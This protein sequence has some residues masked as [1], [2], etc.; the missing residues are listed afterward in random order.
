MFGLG[1]IS[2]GEGGQYAGLGGAGI[3][4]RGSN[5]NPHH[6]P[7]SPNKC[8]EKVYDGSS[9][10]RTHNGGKEEPGNRKPKETKNSLL[11]FPPPLPRGAG[12]GLT[13]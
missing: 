9:V 7:N 6:S 8:S 2:T 12:I 10:K 5:P 1:E 4:L 11:E 3:A 13:W